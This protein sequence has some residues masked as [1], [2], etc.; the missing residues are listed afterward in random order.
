MDAVK[1]I[2]ITCKRPG[3][4]RAGIA[5][6]AKASYPADRFTAAELAALRAEPMLVVL[7]V[8]TPSDAGV[9]G[10]DAPHNVE[11][12]VQFAAEAPAPAPVAKAKPKASRK[13]R[14]G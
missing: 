9:P 12:P 4:R 13:A 5:H 7:E 1:T 8:V 3:F 11:L 14:K 10:P 2:E 6:P